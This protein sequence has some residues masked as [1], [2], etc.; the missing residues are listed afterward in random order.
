MLELPLEATVNQEFLVTLDDQNC[1]IALYQRGP[2]MYLDLR[3][4]GVTVCQGAICRPGMGI[5][6]VATGAWQGQLYMLD[7]R[8]QP[9]RQQA[10]Q[11]RGLGARWRLYWLT[12]DEVREV[13]T[14]N[15]ET[16]L[17]A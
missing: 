6:Q 5:I 17:N 4:G 8:S 10:P 7:E 12:P 11:W 3:V 15:F 13:E 9:D 16:A 2:G 1:T 14:A